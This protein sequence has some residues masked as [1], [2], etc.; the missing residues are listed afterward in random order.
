MRRAAAQQKGYIQT[1]QIKSAAMNAVSPSQFT[2]RGL[3]LLSPVCVKTGSLRFNSWASVAIPNKLKTA[4]MRTKAMT[5][6][7]MGCCQAQPM[8]GPW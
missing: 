1:K 7:L 8:P 2:E 6:I 4:P 5:V 3:K